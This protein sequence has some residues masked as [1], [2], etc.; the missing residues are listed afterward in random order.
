M[1]FADAPISIR[2]ILALML[3][4]LILGVAG[5][6]VRKDGAAYVQATRRHDASQASEIAAQRLAA[7]LYQQQS[8]VRGFLLT[9][10]EGDL[11]PYAAGDGALRLTAAGLR[12]QVSQEQAERVERLLSAFS[13]WREKTDAQ[14]QLMRDRATRARAWD[15]TKTVRQTEAE[16]VQAEIAGAQR[17]Q[18]QALAAAR[19]GVWRRLVDSLTLTAAA[20]AAG[21]VAAAALLHLWITRPMARISSAMTGLAAG[22]ADTAI[23]AMAGAAEPGLA[24]RALEQLRVAALDKRRIESRA[25][26]DRAAAD[27][28]RAAF[29][30]DQAAAAAA[31]AAAVQALG[32][33]LTHL[34]RG[35]LRHRVGALAP[36]YAALQDDFNAAAA[37]LEEI[38]SVIVETTET[39]HADSDGISRA[40]G[41]LSDAAVKQSEAVRDTN[42]AL[43]EVTDV[44]HR[45]AEGARLAHAVVTAAK[46]DAERSGEVVREAVSAM[47]EIEASARQISQII[48]VIDEIAFQTNLLAL[49][50]GVEAARA[51]DAGK[52][53]AVV[54]SEVRALAQR[55]ADAAKEIKTLISAS[56]QQVGRG[57]GLVG[58]TGKALERI[59]AQVAEI[60]SAVAQI[61]QSAE[62]QDAGLKDVGAA[63]RRIDALTGANGEAVEESTAA[64]QFLAQQAG[65]LARLIGKFRIGQGAA[66]DPDEPL[67]VRHMG[68]AKGSLRA[69]TGGRSQRTGG[70]EAEPRRRRPAAA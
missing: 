21:L 1:R 65:Q 70:D 20:M 53:F 37:R 50:A 35:D 31:R 66:E 9:A 44:V 16:T 46:S 3:P 43:G 4:V 5:D 27:D 68:G 39:I 56:T 29:A 24:S 7:D 49:N 33:G 48:G 22:D 51:G 34:R 54:A 52:G 17:A 58:E 11:A 62:A 59:V 57:V 14:L 47:S 18:T 40:A 10:D 45:T 28:E 12:R 55:S 42:L 25:A 67:S 19:E 69:L 2:L 13:A 41:D 63:V 60:N 23:P 61:A 64:T 26:E 6:H 38:I 15:M 32:E 30:A 36:E 8:A